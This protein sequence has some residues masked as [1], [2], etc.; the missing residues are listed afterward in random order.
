MESQLSKKQNILDFLLKSLNDAI[1]RQDIIVNSLIEVVEKLDV[2]INKLEPFINVIETL[3][4]I[5][6]MQNF[7]DPIEKNNKGEI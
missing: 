6:L 4:R 3:D 7:T 5:D 2:I 1:L